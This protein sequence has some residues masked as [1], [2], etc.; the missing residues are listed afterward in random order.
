M[1]VDKPMLHW[2]HS[3]RNLRSSH[4]RRS[5][6]VSDSCRQCEAYLCTRSLTQIL[7]QL[8][9][10][11]GFAGYELRAA[12]SRDAVTHEISELLS[13]VIELASLITKRS[14]EISRFYLFNLA[15]FDRNYLSQLFATCGVGSQE[16]Q[17]PINDAI[18][19]IIAGLEVLDLEEFDNGIRFDCMP[20]LVTA[21][22]LFY[23]FSG[24]KVHQRG[25]FL[26]P[27]FEHL[28]AIVFHI[29]MMTDPV[30]VFLD[31]CPLDQFWIYAPLLQKW[32]QTGTGGLHR[33]SSFLTI[34][35]FFNCDHVI[36]TL[37]KNERES[38]GKLLEST[39][40]DLMTSIHNLLA[41]YL[42][43]G[44]KF[45]KV[46]HQ[47]QS[48][49]IF[50]PEPFI[51]YQPE[52]KI[53]TAQGESVSWGESDFRQES[54]QIRAFLVNSP[55]SIIFFG[56]QFKIY[57]YIASCLSEVVPKLLFGTQISNTLWLDRAMSASVQLFWP[58]YVLIGASFPFRLFLIQSENCSYGSFSR[59]I[60]Y[61][62][63][64]GQPLK[65]QPDSKLLI[66]IFETKI[67][68]FINK[69]YALTLYRP[70]ARCFDSIQR[71]GKTNYYAEDFFQRQALIV[72]V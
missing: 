47:A 48:N 20:L 56:Q 60:D 24:I 65:P 61:T 11:L 22:R 38:L 72:F 50:N 53:P 33:Y 6:K 2:S 64:M 21:G 18:D 45:V 67:L 9:P 7:P 26:H 71:L 37:L 43:H 19:A 32:I 36:L 69:D 59:F 70:Y 63:F 23:L 35:G 54:S 34:Y 49:N 27:I 4:C 52:T 42:E 5:T 16:W 15:T 1:Q 25:T 10:L 12:L 30:R 28:M 66:N 46:L 62:A 57:E 55:A 13:L 68:Q 39:R 14:T 3:S 44:S 8:F 58:L 40:K 17:I 51:N 29:Q 31:I 41:F